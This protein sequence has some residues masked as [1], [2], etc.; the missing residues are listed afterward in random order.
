VYEAEPVITGQ[1][2]P[3]PL[4]TYPV[5][6][7]ELSSEERFAFQQDFTSPAWGVNH[8][9]E[10]YVA[11]VAFFSNEER[12]A[13]PAVDT[14]E[15][16]RSAASLAAT[17]SPAIRSGATNTPVTAPKTA[18][19]A[20]FVVARRCRLTAAWPPTL[21]ARAALPCLRP[22]LFRDSR[23]SRGRGLPDGA[24]VPGEWRM[25]LSTPHC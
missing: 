21:A 11:V 12:Q 17:I 3:W 2:L 7:I 5:D 18:A 1:S 4:A 9:G 14:E 16:G 10:R 19:K 8:A 25:L 24:A 6:E 13:R 23:W 15:S 20:R 22:V